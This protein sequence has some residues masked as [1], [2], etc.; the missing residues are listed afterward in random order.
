MTT[1]FLKSAHCEIPLNCYLASFY[2]IGIHF[3]ILLSTIINKKNAYARK[4]LIPIA[5]ME[6]SQKA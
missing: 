5:S 3:K 6:F 4:E 2:K 1:I